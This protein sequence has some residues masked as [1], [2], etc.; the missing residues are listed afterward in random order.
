MNTRM[1]YLYRDASNYK[2]SEDVVVAGKLQFSDLQP[3]LGNLDEDGF[4]PEDVA[5]PHPGK[6]AKGFPGDDDHC[7][8]E[9]SEDDFEPT[10]DD[11]AMTAQ[12]LIA[13]FERAHADEWPAQM[14]E[15]T[16][17]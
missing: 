14:K 11:P 5:L 12:E 4:C 1:S 10:K 7:W 3:Y 16:S 8:C 6:H 15:L 17:A 2:Y 13:R 9:L